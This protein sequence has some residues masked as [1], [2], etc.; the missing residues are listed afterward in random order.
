MAKHITHPNV[1]P[2]LGVMN[3]PLELISP[4]MPGGG[5]MTYI[6]DQQGADRHSLVRF[7]P[8]AALRNVLTPQQ[9]SDVAEGLRYLHS[10][11][12]VHG[13]LK[14]VCDRCRFLTTVLRRI[15]SSIL[16]DAT[17][18]AR[19]TDFGLA[20]VTQDLDSIRDGLAEYRQNAHWIAPEILDNRGSYGKEADVFSFS[21]VAIEVCH[22]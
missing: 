9:L 17:G 3:D 13:D 5:L 11:D 4:W 12:V 1:V 20:V 21:G 19:I 8:S 6:K 18:R 22:K 14:P 15:Q 7:P 10:C 2:I 16:V